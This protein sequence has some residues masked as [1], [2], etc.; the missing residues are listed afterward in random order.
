MPIWISLYLVIFPFISTTKILEKAKAEG[1]GK[2]TLLIILLFPLVIPVLIFWLL[3]K[4]KIPQ[5]EKLTYKKVLWS[6][7]W[8]ILSGSTSLHSNLNYRHRKSTERLLMS[9]L[10]FVIETFALFRKKSYF[11]ILSWNIFCFCWEEPKVHTSRNNR[12]C[13]CRFQ[14][15]GLSRFGP[16]VG[17]SHKINVD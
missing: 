17:V 14:C 16:F 10:Y 6:D 4:L 9:F 2:F 7:I 1:C 15:L 8:D 13:T 5:L 3:K 12:I 11:N